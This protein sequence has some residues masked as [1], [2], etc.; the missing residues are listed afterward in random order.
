M[1]MI[2][3]EPEWY[4]IQEFAK[5]VPWNPY[6]KEQEHGKKTGFGIKNLHVLARGEIDIKVNTKKKFQVTLRITAD[7]YYKAYINGSFV[8]Q[9][10]APAYP[11][12]Y[13]YNRIDITPFVRPGKNIVAV[14]AYYQGLVNRVWNSGDG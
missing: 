6:H 7:D 13:Y 14:H 9:G 12:A 11:E 8:G 1:A 3:F 4:T 5:I 10:P 2:K